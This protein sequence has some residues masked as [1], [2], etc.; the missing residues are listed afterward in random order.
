MDKNHS[1]L[2]E[3][4]VSSPQLDHLVRIARTEGALGAK[5]SGGG[6]GGNIIA[7][8]HN[9]TADHIAESLGLAGAVHTLIAV[10][11]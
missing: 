6:R 7:L 2:G 1:L 11:R 9:T 10:I 4:G 3:I 5:L 8:A